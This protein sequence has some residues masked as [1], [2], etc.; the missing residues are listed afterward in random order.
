MRNSLAYFRAALLSLQVELQF[1]TN[2]ILGLLRS[3][4]S[5]TVM[6]LLWLKVYDQ[7][8]IIAGLTQA[9]MV[10]YY[11]AVFALSPFLNL[12]TD[13][14]LWAAIKY[15]KLSHYLLLPINYYWYSTAR[16]FGAATINLLL[17]PLLLL[18]GRWLTGIS[19]SAYF[20]AHK[21]FLFLVALINATL[22]ARA[23][24]FLRGLLGFWLEDV[25]LISW[26]DRVIISLLSGKYFPLTFLPLSIRAW[27]L[28]LPFQAI[29]SA[30][31]EVLLSPAVDIRL[32]MRT[33]YNSLWAFLLTSLVK[34]SWSKGVSK[35]QAAG[36]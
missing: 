28:Y 23:I 11:I 17:F 6:L 35:Y 34:Y 15:G 30:P 19:F 18:Y 5:V 31:I 27:F 36:G 1:R 24:S 3:F 22:I 16:K 14:D 2:F 12:E 26:L 13:W 20:S 29:F 25:G 4:V 10:A 32:V 9:D 21:F 33:A 7:A 8:D